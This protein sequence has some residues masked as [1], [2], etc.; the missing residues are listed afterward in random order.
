MTCGFGSSLPARYVECV[1]HRRLP[2]D[3]GWNLWPLVHA[4]SLF[5]LPAGHLGSGRRHRALGLGADGIRAAQFS[6]DGWSNCGRVGDPR[7]VSAHPTSDLHG[8]LPVHVGWRGRTLVVEGRPV[9]Q[10]GPRGC[11]RSDLLRGGV[12]RGAVSG[13]RAIL[14]QHLAD[15]PVRFLNRRDGEQRRPVVEMVRPEASS[16]AF[17]SERRHS[18]G[19]QT[20]R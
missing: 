7:T 13:V 3:G 8:S 18:K 11:D 10:P 9:R 17:R 1:I 14:G 5:G 4:K 19:G 12:D 16:S 2:G 20:D 6:C 15:D